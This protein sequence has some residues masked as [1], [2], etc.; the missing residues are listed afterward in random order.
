MDYPMV[1]RL[2]AYSLLAV[3]YT[4]LAIELLMR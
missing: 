3:A 4:A 2:I 1:I